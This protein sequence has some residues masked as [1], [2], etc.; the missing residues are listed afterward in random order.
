LGQTTN[1]VTD[2]EWVIA[3]SR[4]VGTRGVLLAGMSLG[5][6]ESGGVRGAYC[7]VASGSA[8]TV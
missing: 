5:H 1:A 7:T 3:R 6:T 2:R 8:K 4:S